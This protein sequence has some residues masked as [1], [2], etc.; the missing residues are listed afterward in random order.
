MNAGDY[1]IFYYSEQIY[2]ELSLINLLM[3]MPHFP[4]VNNQKIHFFYIRK[5]QKQGVKKPLK[6]NV[7]KILGFIKFL[8]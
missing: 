7:Q 4:E 2:L 1:Y 5:L 3:I 6:I 8:K